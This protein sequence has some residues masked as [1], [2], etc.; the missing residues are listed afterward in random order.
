M[1]GWTNS[2]ALGS[3][4]EKGM[5]IFKKPDACNLDAGTEEGFERK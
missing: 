3:L 1:F 2:V 5:R 4:G